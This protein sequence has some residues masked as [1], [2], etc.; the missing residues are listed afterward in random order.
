MTCNLFSRYTNKGSIPK[1]EE[2]Y[3]WKVPQSERESAIFKSF[4]LDVLDNY[5]DNGLAIHVNKCL[6]AKDY[7]EFLGY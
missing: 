4:T 5:N 1:D 3:A 6:F 2:M 7:L